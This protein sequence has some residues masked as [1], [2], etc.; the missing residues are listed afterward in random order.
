[1]YFLAE[2]AATQPAFQNHLGTLRAQASI[3]GK[4]SSRL[5]TSGNEKRLSSAWKFL[6][7]T[8]NLNFNIGHHEMPSGRLLI[9]AVATLEPKFMVKNEDEHSGYNNAQLGTDT[10][11]QKVQLETSNE[12]STELDD[13]ERLRRM[14]ISKAN[15]GNTPWNKGRKH[16][17]GKTSSSNLYFVLISLFP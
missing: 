9:K 10:R 7:I 8:K 11:P 16:S 17:P 2:F 12:D 15:K 3:H 14:R 13:K 1:M 4:V 5:F 6:D